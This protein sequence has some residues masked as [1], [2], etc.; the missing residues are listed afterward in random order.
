M[1]EFGRYILSVVTAAMIV[2]ICCSIFHEKSLMGALTRM[3]GGLFLAIVMLSPVAHW[4]YD[5]VTTFAQSFEIAGADAAREG[6]NLA[7]DAMSA[8]IKEEISAYILDKAESLHAELTVEVMLSSG[9]SPVPESV[10]IKGNVSPYAKAQLQRIM[11]KDLGIP[12]ERQI[13]IG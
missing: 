5:V 4:D 7:A 6:S 1:A 8:I 9:E 3:I 13:W 10:R 2:C 12:K 11:E